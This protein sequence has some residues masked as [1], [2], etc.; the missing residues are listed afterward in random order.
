MDLFGGKLNGLDLFSGIAGLGGDAL[1]EWVKTIAYCENDRYAQAVLLSRMAR[2]EIDVAPIHDNVETLR[3]RDLPVPID[4]IIAG[5]PCQDISVAGRRAGLG[6]NRS[7]L[8]FEI[9]RLV[10]EL[11]PRFVFL[12]NTSGITCPPMEPGREREPT[13]LGI[14]AGEL[15]ALRYDC[16]W[17][18]L[19]AFDMGAPHERA[20]W[21]LL[22]HT[23]DTRKRREPRQ[24]EVEKTSRNIGGQRLQKQQ[25]LGRGSSYG[26]AGIP[27]PERRTSWTIEP[28]VGRVVHGLSMRSDRIRALGNSVVPQCAREAFERL[29]GFK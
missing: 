27:S 26:H 22:A 6:G 5:F 18:F 3:G 15:A 9:K 16:R 29:I 13:P 11:R 19:R 1:G 20:R 28:A 21:F 23:S 7:G 2:G 10:G 24:K 8:F 17:G 4:I 12:E 14:V 25:R